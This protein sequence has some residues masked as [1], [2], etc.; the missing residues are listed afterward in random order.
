MFRSLLLDFVN[1]SVNIISEMKGKR[2]RWRQDTLYAIFRQVL[3]NLKVPNVTDIFVYHVMLKVI[4][5][6]CLS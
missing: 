4:L 1:D 2:T 6:S 5:C 3:L